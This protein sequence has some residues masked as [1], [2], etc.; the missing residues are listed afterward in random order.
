DDLATR[1]LL[2]RVLVLVMGEFGRTPRLNK[3]MANVSSVP[4][5]DHWAN[6]MSVMLAGGGLQ[7]GQVVGATNARAEHPVDRPLSPADLLATV[8][9]VL[10]FAPSLPSPALRGRPIAILDEGKPIAEAF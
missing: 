7:G 8:Y 3:G 9:H 4:G 2:N 10:G 6:A 1:G 5:R